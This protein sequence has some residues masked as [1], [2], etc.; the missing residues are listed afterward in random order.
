VWRVS[1]PGYRSVSVT[2]S[3]GQVRRVTL[4]RA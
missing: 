2:V 4:E 3:A 1:A